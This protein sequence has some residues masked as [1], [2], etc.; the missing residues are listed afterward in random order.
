MAAKTLLHNHPGR[1]TVTVLEKHSTIGGLWPTEPEHN[2]GLLN[3]EMP[4]NQSKHTVSFSDLAWASVDLGVASRSL[5]NGNVDSS[6]TAKHLD[7]IPMFPKA[8]HVGRYLQT[9]AQKYLIQAEIYLRSTVTSVVQEHSE[10]GRRWKVHWTSSPGN[11]ENGVRSQSPNGQSSQQEEGS[12]HAQA[13]FDY[14]I[15]ASGFFGVPKM[16]PLPGLDMFPGSILHSTDLRKLGALVTDISKPKT[17]N[18]ITRAARRNDK[19]DQPKIVVVGG[20]MS[21]AEAAASLAMQISTARHSP[22]SS[23]DDKCDIQVYHVTSRPFYVLPTY[24]PVDPLTTTSQDLEGKPFSHVPSFG[25]LDLCMNNLTRRRPGPISDSQGPIPPAQLKAIHD[26]LSALVGGDQGDLG[27]EALHITK[28]YHEK[29]PRVVILDDYAEFV[30]SGAIIPILGNTD[31]LGISAGGGGLVTIKVKGEDRILENIK[32]VVMATGFTSQQS[33]QWL[34][35]EILA[36][37]QYDSTHNRMPIMLQ[38]RS[39]CHSEIPHLGFVGLYEG[40]YWGIM[41]M[42]ARML[43]WQWAGENGG[44]NPPEPAILREAEE[45]RRRMLSTRATLRDR[46]DSASQFWMGDFVGYMESFARGLR[47]KRTE[48]DGF[49]ERGGPST[50]PRYSDAR[51]NATEVLAGLRSLERTMRRAAGEGAFIAKA[52]FRA[53]HGIWKMQRNL[54]SS[55]ATYPSGKFT[56]VARFHP[57]LPTNSKYDAEYLYI[58]EGELATDRGI[59]MRVSRRYVYRYQEHTDQMTAWFVKPE[60]SK[61]VDYLF[62]GLRFQ[63]PG[64][65]SVTASTIHDVDRGWVATGHHLCID[66]DYNSRYLFRF[67]GAALER[68]KIG[69]E[70][71]GPKKDY[72]TDTWYT[73]E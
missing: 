53:M 25:P 18:N 50:A 62:H 6:P 21:G 43:A 68:F 73:R 47:I 52:A 51:D 39:Y 40:P 38:H 41:E 71:K 35:K 27:S 56:G 4:T 59:T 13:A 23:D 22:Q 26:Y 60:D 9:Y 36:V 49:E 5:A 10:I 45:E 67:R 65:E 32:A 63:V 42:Q 46:P 58:E 15:V 61:S 54:T 12:R 3:P 19:E 8:W 30:R 72:M 57:R 31:G 70:V 24:V 55:I 34:P 7:E 29:P 16:L 14:L 2:D 37:L 66:D 20:G 1:F 28:E 69:Y 33:L 64:D 48:L 11:P 17:N 44:K